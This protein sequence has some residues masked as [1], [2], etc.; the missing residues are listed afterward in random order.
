MPLIQMKPDHQ[1]VVHAPGAETVALSA[2]GRAWAIYLTGRGESY[3]MLDV[4]PGRYRA[5]WFR[6]GDGAR[7]GERTVTHGK[8]ALRMDTPSFEEDAVLRLTSLR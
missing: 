2:R 1:T 7:L 3:L 8:G 6:P 5:E 4:P